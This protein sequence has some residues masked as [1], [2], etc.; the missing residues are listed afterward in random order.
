MF[1]YQGCVHL[2]V[3][4]FFSLWIILALVGLPDVGWESDWFR[5]Y[6]V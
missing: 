2:M 5:V 4:T 1:P 6:D 3:F